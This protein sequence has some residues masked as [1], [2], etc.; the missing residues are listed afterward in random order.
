MVFLIT[1]CS[2]LGQEDNT[3]DDVGKGHRLAAVLCAICHV[4]ASDQRFA[5]T[6]NPPAPSFGS[7]AQRKDANADSLQNFMSKK[8]PSSDNPRSYLTNDQVRQ[9][10]AYLLSLRK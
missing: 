8:H 6:L 5:P 9:V 4:A 3:A 7:I 10:V 1:A 2:A